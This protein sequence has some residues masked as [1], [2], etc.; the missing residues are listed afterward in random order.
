MC[1]I[2]WHSYN[3]E[4]AVV[5]SF[6]GSMRSSFYIIDRDNMNAQILAEMWDDGWATERTTMPKKKMKVK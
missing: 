1:V 2:I 3:F 5:K 6:V 4:Q